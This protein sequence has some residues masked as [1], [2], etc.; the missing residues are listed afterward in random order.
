MTRQVEAYKDKTVDIK[1]GDGSVTRV[2]KLREPEPP[3]EPPE[4]GPEW[5]VN[6]PL[7]FAQANTLEVLLRAYPHVKAAKS[8]LEDAIWQAQKRYERKYPT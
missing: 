8:R 1:W 3:P 2:E 6:V 5:P 7:T 4:P